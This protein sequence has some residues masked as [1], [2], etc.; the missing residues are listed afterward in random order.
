MYDLALK[1]NELMNRGGGGVFGFLFFFGRGGG[2]VF[3][4]LISEI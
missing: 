4:F 1:V 2:C 3:I